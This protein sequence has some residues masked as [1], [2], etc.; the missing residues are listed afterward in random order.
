MAIKE[1]WKIE[2]LEEDKNKKIA[3]I[4]GGPSGITAAAFLA[5]RG[6]KT[7]IYEKHKEIRWTF[8]SWY[9]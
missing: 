5:R 2:K 6:F 8:I 1:G 3:I 9:T 4:G 7:H